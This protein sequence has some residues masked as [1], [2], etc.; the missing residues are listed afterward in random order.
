MKK[1]PLLRSLVL[2]LAMLV[3]LPTFA[4]VKRI[5]R[6]LDHLRRVDALGHHQQ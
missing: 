5:Q 3:S 2:S 1:T 6:L 4:A